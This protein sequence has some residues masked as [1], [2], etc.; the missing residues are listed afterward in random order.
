MTITTPCSRPDNLSKVFESINFDKINKWII[1]YDTSKGRSY[2]HKFNHEKI[3]E[4]EAN[5]DMEKDPAAGHFQHN[6]AMILVK[7]QYIYRIDDDNVV[8]P[9]FWNINFE[10]TDDPATLIYTF[11]SVKRNGHVYTKGNKP[12]PCNIDT[13][14][15][16]V[17][18]KLIQDDRWSVTKG[19][20]GRFIKA[21]VEKNKGKFHY[22][23]K[24]LAYYNYLR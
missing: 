21:M 10:L 8:H 16:C 14:C 13:A 7:N 3:I 20:D 18:T 6:A 15:F 12:L 17:H 11:D 2:T 22:I 5:S 24:V 1:S 4:I 19:A 9:D 23:P